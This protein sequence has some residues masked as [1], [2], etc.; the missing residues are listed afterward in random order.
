MKWS[1]IFLFSLLYCNRAPGDKENEAGQKAVAGDRF[2]VCFVYHRFG[3]DRYT[4]TNISISDFRTHLEY[5][6][7]NSFNVL[8]LSEAVKY[9]KNTGENNKVAVIT[10]DDGYTSFLSGA[11]PLLKE[12]GFPATLFVNTE[13]IG[14]GSYLNW[15]ELRQVKKAGIEIGNH[16]HSH[17][18]FLNLH[19]HDHVKIFREELAKAQQLLKEHLDVVPSVFAYPYGEYTPEMKE[20]VNQMGFIA[21]AAQNSGVM[22]TKGDYYAIPRYPMANAYAAVEDFADK[23]NMQPLEVQ[24]DPKSVVVGEKNPPVLTLTFKTD[25]L[26]YERLQC[27]VQ[28]GECSLEILQKKPLKIRVKSKKPLTRRRTLY[29]ITVPSQKGGWHWYS[30]LW[31]QAD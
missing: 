8:T 22:H 12:F 18:Y 25:S 5:L 23:L 6:K 26:A 10:V 31:V 21:A 17:P 15:D 16:S 28:G 14:N 19:Q 30:H 1:L 11:L 20:A 29:T 7:A 2:F 13:T 24:E 4:S 27:F 9:L 3:D